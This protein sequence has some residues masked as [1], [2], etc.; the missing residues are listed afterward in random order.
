VGLKTCKNGLWIRKYQSRLGTWPIF[1]AGVSVREA[2]S[3]SGRDTYHTGVVHKIASMKHHLVDV[4]PSL[5]ESD[6][7]AEGELATAS[8]LALSPANHPRGPA[9]DLHDIKGVHLEPSI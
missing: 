6:S 3:L 7:L 2:H 4:L 1:V 5:E 9:E 8:P